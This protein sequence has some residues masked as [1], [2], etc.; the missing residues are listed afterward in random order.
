MQKIVSTIEVNPRVIFPEDVEDS[1][2]AMSEDEDVEFAADVPTRGDSEK[3]RI[4]HQ[5]EHLT[6]FNNCAACEEPLQ[7]PAPSCKTCLTAYHYRCRSELKNIC[8]CFAYSN[9]SSEDMTAMLEKA[10]EE[11][12]IHAKHGDLKVKTPPKASMMELKC[13]A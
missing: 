8:L 6:G 7:F 9:Q 5:V 10:M 2:S 13:Q 3:W 12:K 1:E 11:A 4:I